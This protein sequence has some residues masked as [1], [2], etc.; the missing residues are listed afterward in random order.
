MTYDA[1]VERLDEFRSL[2]PGWDS[3]GANSI[4]EKAIEAAEQIIRRNPLLLLHVCP[5]CTGGIQLEWHK[6]WRDI[7]LEIEPTGQSFKYLI[8][9]SREGEFCSRKQAAVLVERLLLEEVR[10]DNRE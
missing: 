2:E 10:D 4:T 3:Y 7:E 1:A 9:D 5:L 8:Q 6:R